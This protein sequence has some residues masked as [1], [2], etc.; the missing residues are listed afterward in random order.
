MHLNLSVRSTLRARCGQPPPPGVVT[1]GIPYLVPKITCALW[2]RCIGTGIH[3]RGAFPS[4]AAMDLRVRA[5]G[6]RKGLS[7]AH[8]LG[9]TV[10]VLS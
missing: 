1:G 3:G 5:L 10:L 4:V 2:P 7:A 9:R 6:Q 8:K